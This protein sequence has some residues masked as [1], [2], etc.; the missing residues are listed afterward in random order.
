MHFCI[1]NPFSGFMD[2]EATHYDHAYN[3]QHIQAT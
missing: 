1:A 3:M 2:D